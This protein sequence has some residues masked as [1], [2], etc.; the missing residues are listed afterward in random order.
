V[1]ANPLCG[2]CPELEGHTSGIERR[3]QLAV[4]GE[5]HVEDAGGLHF[6]GVDDP[7]VRVVGDYHQLAHHGAANVFHTCRD[8]VSGGIDQM[9]VL[10]PEAIA[11][12]GRL[13][14]QG[15]PAADG[16]RLA[17]DAD[18]GVAVI[19]QFQAAGARRTAHQCER[20]RIKPVRPRA[21]D[22]HGTATQRRAGQ[23]WV[24]ADREDTTAQFIEAPGQVATAQVLFVALVHDQIQAAGIGA[25]WNAVQGAVPRVGI[26]RRERLRPAGFS[27]TSV[28]AGGIP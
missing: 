14:R 22:R 8:S 18:A 24:A 28:A 5:Q 1:Q 25:Q 15:P 23:L 26:H 4:V 13:H 2:R 27:R 6:G 19:A 7:V 21:L 17:V 12:A 3:A 10:A 11:Q 9:R 16:T 20:E